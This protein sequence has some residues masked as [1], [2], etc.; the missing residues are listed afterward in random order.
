M[1]DHKDAYMY[2]SSCAT[3]YSDHFVPLDLTKAQAV[4]QTTCY[5]IFWVPADCG[6]R[7]QLAYSGFQ[8][9]HWH[10]SFSRMYTCI[11]HCLQYKGKV[12]RF[13]LTSDPSLARLIGRQPHIKVDSCMPFHCRAVSKPD[14]Q[15]HSQSHDLS[16]DLG[17]SLMIGN[18]NQFDQIQSI[19]WSK[20]I[21]DC[22]IA[23]SAWLS[24][25]GPVCTAT[26]RSN[27][28]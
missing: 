21:A 4:K 18:C 13:K 23:K 3:S 11:W 19:I 14:L 8:A 22:Q 26:G 28:K 2:A 25:Y 6:R 1:I 12:R 17:C 24:I 10:G 15:W 9:F 16:Q 27:Y 7:L 20:S 5:N